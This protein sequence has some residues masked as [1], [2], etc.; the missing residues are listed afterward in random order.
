MSREYLRVP[1]MA[2]SLTTV[3]VL[4]LPLYDQQSASGGLGWHSN[5]TVGHS[6]PDKLSRISRSV[7]GPS[8]GGGK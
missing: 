3:E 5:N 7:L 8:E 6:Y 4:H 1:G 2:T